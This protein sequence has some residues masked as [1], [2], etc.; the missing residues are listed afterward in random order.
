M[1]L[2]LG[3]PQ[4]ANF[5]STHPLHRKSVHGAMPVATLSEFVLPFI[6]PNY[7]SVA[8]S[9][10]CVQCMWYTVMSRCSKIH[11]YC[12]MLHRHES[13]P[14]VPMY[15]AHTAMYNDQHTDQCT[16]VHHC[17]QHVHIK[18]L[19][20]CL[21]TCVVVTPC[22][23]MQFVHCIVSYLHTSTTCGDSERAVLLIICWS[24]V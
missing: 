15:H 19:Y 23:M 1:K 2:W 17:L 11:L 12:A 8:Y 16:S 21:V 10:L 6:F 5:P 4:L 22:I 24:A 20:V 18:E 14:P 13:M 7:L 3:L 9:W